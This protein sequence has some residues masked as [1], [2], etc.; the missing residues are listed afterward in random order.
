MKL[1]ELTGAYQSVLE[2]LTECVDDG[3]KFEALTDQLEQCE[4]DIKIKVE[5]CAKMVRVMDARAAAYR[6]EADFFAAKAKAANGS[7]ERLE[8]YIQRCMES[9]GLERVE[10]DTLS[11]KLCQNGQ[12][13][14]LVDGDVPRKF[15]IKQEPKVNNQA[16]KEALLAG[17]KLKFAKL[18]YGKHIR[19][20]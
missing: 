11:V 19:I 9:I 3:V 1:Y 8:E 10:G 6:R 5:N 18:N 4:S 13:S 7:S 16:I 12:P 20:T 14:L 15:T 2:E 17:K